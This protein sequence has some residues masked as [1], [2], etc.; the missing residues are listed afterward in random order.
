MFKRV[1]IFF[2][3]ILKSGWTDLGWLENKKMW[4]QVSVLAFP[5]HFQ[6]TGKRE[7]K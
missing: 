3:T 6:G 2:F 5:L 1:H 4:L 7:L